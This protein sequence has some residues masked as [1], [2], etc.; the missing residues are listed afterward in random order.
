MSA[1]MREHAEAA[2]GVVVLAVV[3][4]MWMGVPC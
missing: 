4:W 2:A 3:L 1:R